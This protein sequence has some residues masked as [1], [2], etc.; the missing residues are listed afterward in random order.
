MCRRTWASSPL[1]SHCLR[2]RLR[3]DSSGSLGSILIMCAC[4]IRLS[5]TG[6]TAPLR[7]DRP[8][9]SDRCPTS[10]AQMLGDGSIEAS[11]TYRSTLRQNARHD[12]ERRLP[13]PARRE[14]HALAA[15]ETRCGATAGHRP[16]TCEACGRRECFS[17]ISRGTA[18][19][20]ALDHGPCHQ[21]LCL[22][23]RV[24]SQR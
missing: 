20:R 11:R 19:L 4:S 10:I 8:T 1:C 24:R 6:Q 16:L 5:L 14:S 17:R 3:A 12:C 15:Y 2:K 21:R 13:L 7:E 18:A 23:R 9:R 22:M